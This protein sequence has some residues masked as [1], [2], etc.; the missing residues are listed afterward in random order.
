MGM[1]GSF[2][3]TISISPSPL[4][5]DLL[6]RRSLLSDL[7][8][9]EAFT[10]L[11]GLVGF[12]VGASLIGLVVLATAGASFTATAFGG[13]VLATV[14]LGTEAFEAGA[15]GEEA[16]VG[17]AVATGA[18]FLVGTA[19]LDGALAVTVVGAFG[20]VGVVG[21]SDLAGGGGDF[22]EGALTAGF[23]SF[24]LDIVAR[25]RDARSRLSRSR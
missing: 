5:A 15:F 1:G 23:F 19:A 7:E 2:G 18:A 14:A 12:A 16:F 8:A 9:D 17:A 11:E 24:V 22:L 10:G 20:L 6:G 3:T 13:G 4:S 21:L 25:L